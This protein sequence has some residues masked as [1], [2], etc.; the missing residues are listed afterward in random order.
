[1]N[2]TNYVEK[3]L[4]TFDELPFNEVD[5]LVLCEL[6]YLHFTRSVSG[7]PAKTLRDLCENMQQLNQDTLLPK[8]NLKLMKEIRKSPRF[9][10]I[11]V[12]YFRE[13]NSV[14]KEMRFAA[15]VFELS[16]DLH[17]VAFRGTDIT[18]LGWKEDFNMAILQAIPSQ[19]EALKYLE[20]VSTKLQGDL[21]L[22]G[23]SKGGNLVV[24]AG[25]FCN[26]S[27]RQRIVAVYDHDGPGFREDIFHDERYI[28]LMPRIHKTVPHNSVI[29]MLLNVT[30]YYEVVE[31]NS[32][33]VL[34]HNPFSWEVV[35]NRQFKKLPKTARVSV[36]TDMTLT[37][38]IYSLDAPTTQKLVD[39]LFSVLYSGGATTVPQLLHSP[40]RSLN[41][42]RKGFKNLDEQSR[43]LLLGNGKELLRLW[44]ES[45]WQVSKKDR[46]D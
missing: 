29:G 43:Q 12:G 2:I 19:K 27:V 3:N 8:Q 17:Y 33:S 24:Y 42:M 39:A 25:V 28:E 35:Q 21:I 38:W 16:P 20:E 46:R 32:I 45:M 18:L 14:E 41:N 7:A 4:S 9:G 34:Q 5:S 31:S 6:S 10:D 11:K 37:K 1:M 40:I 15:M 30:Q 26:R 22:G 23:H 36:A 44:F 13:R